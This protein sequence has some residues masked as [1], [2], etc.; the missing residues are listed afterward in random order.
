MLAMPNVQ[1]LL[2]SWHKI[3]CDAIIGHLL[4]KAIILLG[5][6]H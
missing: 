3:S 2:D 4:V 6:I 1:V 5:V